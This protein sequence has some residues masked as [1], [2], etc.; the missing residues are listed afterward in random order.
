MFTY[1][2]PRFGFHFSVG[3]VTVCGITVN[4]F[5]IFGKIGIGLDGLVVTCIDFGRLRLC[6][7]FCV[8]LFSF[9][10]ERTSHISGSKSPLLWRFNISC[11]ILKCFWNWVCA[12]ICALLYCV[13][14]LKFGGEFGFPGIP[15]V[16]LVDPFSPSICFCFL[17]FCSRLKS[18]SLNWNTLPPEDIGNFE[19]SFRLIFP[20]AELVEGKL[21]RCKLGGGFF[22]ID[23]PGFNLRKRG[24]LPFA[25]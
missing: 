17:R 25:D 6:N 10:K 20:L 13:V 18:G 11:C 21:S 1:F 19:L 3:L 9:I 12:A 16:G 23:T 22:I 5:G 14:V 8:G 4:D 2:F 15:P 7:K 24:G